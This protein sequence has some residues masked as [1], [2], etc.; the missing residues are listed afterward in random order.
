MLLNHS[1]SDV[2]EAAANE[3]LNAVDSIWADIS[4]VLSKLS[5]HIGN[6]EISLLIV[7]KGILAIIVLQFLASRLLRRVDRRL[8]RLQHMRGSDRILTMKMLSIFIYFIAF[9]IIAQLLGINLTAL[10]VLGGAL[11]VGVGFGLQKIASNFISG[12]ILLFEKSIE[13]GDVLEIAPGVNGFVR[14]TYARYTRVETADGREILIPNEEFIT[15][16]V[17]TLTH[18]TRQARIEIKVAVAYE[19]DI[20]AVQKLMID[21]AKRHPLCMADPKPNCFLTEFEDSGVGLV[22]LFWVAD[23][24][25]G[26]LSPRSD[27]MLGILQAFK[28]HNISIPYPQRELRVTNTTPE[29]IAEAGA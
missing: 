18:T 13:I 16:R 24:A 28:A 3:A 8:G 27:V 10:S 29:D 11:G 21:V 15:Q 17:T 6:T 25:A 22:L 20:P 12:I 2:P 26:R 5:I 1:P 14:Q 23:V 19:S 4:S 9:I 7:L